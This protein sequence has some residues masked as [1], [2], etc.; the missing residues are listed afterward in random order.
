[1][2][3]TSRRHNVAALQ[4][5]A[6]LLFTLAPF[7]ASLIAAVFSLLATQLL[8]RANRLELAQ[9]EA[10]LAQAEQRLERRTWEPCPDCTDGRQRDHVPC[11]TCDGTAR[12]N[13]GSLVAILANRLEI[14]EK[15]PAWP[16][17]GVTVA[18]VQAAYPKLRPALAADVARAWRS[19]QRRERI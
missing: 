4:R 19:D 1:M 7:L 6:L 10:E 13:T 8:R 9:V 16:D 11:E 12:L 5:R 18:Q 15:T 2:I 17:E 3:F 14:P